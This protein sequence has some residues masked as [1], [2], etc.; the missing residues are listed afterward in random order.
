MIAELVFDCKNLIGE[1]ALWDSQ[2]NCLYW[3]DILNGKVMCWDEDS[4]EVITYDVGKYV[5]TVAISEYGKL[6]LALQDGIYLYD[7]SDGVLECISEIE[8][9]I[10][11]NRFNDGK[12]DPAGRFWAG[13][14]QI[15]PIEATGSLY[16]LSENLEIKK[17]LYGITIS[18]GLTWSLDHQKMYYI[19]TPTLEIK[20][21][22]FDPKSSNIEFDSV[23]AKVDGNNG[24]PDGMTIDENGNL[25]V[26]MYGGGC[27]NCFEEVSGKI[28][29]KITLPTL[30]V[31]SC[32]F[33]G[34][35]LS[36]LYITTAMDGLTKSEI[37]RQ[38]Y[39]GGLFKAKPGVKGVRFKNH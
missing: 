13:T 11:L 31:T 34:E 37:V 21:Y 14:M 10:P 33:G 12:C 5:G 28:I 29:D 36:T 3:V 32:V 20:C 38:P 18:N 15:N 8:S 1:G 27:V 26:A 19:D 6:L 30:H 22:H 25:W 9:D 2:H 23:V 24:V 17:K 7:P 39:A 4:S 35:D 16:L